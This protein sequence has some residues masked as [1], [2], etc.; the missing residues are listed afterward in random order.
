V[1]LRCTGRLLKILGKQELAEAEPSD[2]DWYANLVWLDGRK[3]VLLAHAA[4]LFPIYV[5]DVRA[6]E[7][8]PIAPFVSA[9]IKDALRRETLPPDTF[10]PLDPNEVRIAK[11]ASKSIVASMNDMQQQ[12]RHRLRYFGSLDPSDANALNRELRHTPYGARDYAYPIELAA[13]QAAKLH[14]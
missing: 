12:A 1:I 4:T 9:H 10:G 11:T 5:P 13:Q 2:D 7:L 14:P 6:K 3:W 8:R